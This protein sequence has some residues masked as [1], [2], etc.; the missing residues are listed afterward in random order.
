MIG[1]NG[2][3][4]GDEQPSSSDAPLF[5]RPPEREGCTLPG[6]GRFPVNL[7]FSGRNISDEGDS[8][9]SGVAWEYLPGARSGP[10]ALKMPLEGYQVAPARQERGGR[11]GRVSRR[12]S[13]TFG[14]PV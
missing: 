7:G 11:S 13:R 1:S 12:P 6:A 8:C 2:S 14:A 10:M 4:R 9:P 3:L 5:R